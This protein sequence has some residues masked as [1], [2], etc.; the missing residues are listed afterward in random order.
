[1]TNA[2]LAEQLAALAAPLADSLGLVLWGVELSFG[3]RG[4]VRVFVEAK[5]DDAASPREADDAHG[6]LSAQ[7]VSIDQ[8]A[9]L[10]RLLGLALDVEDLMPGAYVLE[11]SSPGFERRYFTASQLAGAVGELV[12]ISLRQGAD[13]GDRTVRGRLVSAPDEAEAACG[14]FALEP[15]K[16]DAL[17]FTFATVKKARRIHVFPEK[18]KPGKGSGKAGG[19]KTTE[20]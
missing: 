7:G 1:M 19:G 4:L 2:R 20:K 3:Q 8:C 6:P 10:S 14:V 16:G 12:E 5:A 13:G 15:E 17:T 9:H 11:V 18:T